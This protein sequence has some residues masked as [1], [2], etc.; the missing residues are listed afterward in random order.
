MSLL[1]SAK[2]SKI[3]IEKAR[4]EFE[5]VVRWFQIIFEKVPVRRYVLLMWCFTVTCFLY[6]PSRKRLK[7]ESEFGQCEIVRDE[8]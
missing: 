4:D 1:I 2:K 5:K 3:K 7:E 8:L 6:N